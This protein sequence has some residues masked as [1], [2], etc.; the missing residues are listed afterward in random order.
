[1]EPTRLSKLSEPAICQIEPFSVSISI[2]CPLVRA[3]T[4]GG[5]TWSMIRRPALSM[6]FQTARR[7]CACSG[8]RCQ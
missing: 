8:K 3:R 4:F 7:A 1:L 6:P 5:S 2:S